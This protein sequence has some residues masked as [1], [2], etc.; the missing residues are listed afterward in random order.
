MHYRTR[1]KFCGITRLQDAEL[2]VELGVDALGF[3][4][5]QASPRYIEPKA[6]ALIISKLPSFITAVG[7]VVDRSSDEV[8]DI[9]AKTSIDLVQCHGDESALSCEQ[10]L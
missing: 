4:F 2:A 6:A 3:V 9:I 7:L 10:L 5:H 1:V 8:N